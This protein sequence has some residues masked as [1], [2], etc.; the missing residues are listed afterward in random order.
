MINDEKRGEESETDGK[1]FQR[2]P[3]KEKSDEQRVNYSGKSEI[4]RKVT[5]QRQ[6][7]RQ[8]GM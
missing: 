4:E 7:D 6:T 3:E 5:R 2:E 8:R 1:E